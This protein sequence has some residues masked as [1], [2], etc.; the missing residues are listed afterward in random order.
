MYN[1]FYRNPKPETMKKN[2][3][4]YA[5]TFKK[6][7]KWLKEH[8]SPLNSCKNKFLLEMYQILVTGSRKIT[9]KM[10]TAIQ[11]GIKKCNQN[12]N[13][14]ESL[15]QEADA[16]IK[17]ILD[18]IKMVRSLAESKGDYAVQFIDDVYEKTK[19]NYRITSKQMAAL[20]KIYKRCG[21]DLFKGEEN[22]KSS[23][24]ENN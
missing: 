6:E 7:I 4:F 5:E 18:K 23:S 3:E 11:N 2:R 10:A 12:P 15:R 24:K 9:P 17:P 16:K 14:N 21:D 13:Y 22:E 20:N 1:R 19:Q 8:M